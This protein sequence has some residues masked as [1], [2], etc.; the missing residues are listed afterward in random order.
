MTERATIA[1]P[2]AR[3]VFGLARDEGR[4]EAWSSMLVLICEIAAV[5][6][7]RIV[8][9]DPE[10]DRDVVAG[11]FFDLAG[12]RLDPQGRNLLRILMENRRMGL[13]PQILESYEVYRAGEER[14]GLAKVTSARPL[15][16]DQE[17]A[18][19]E[20]LG[21]SLGHGVELECVVDETLIGGAVI[22]IGDR[23]IDGSALGGL[24]QLAHDLG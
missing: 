14:S 19:R 1:R 8:I 24:E 23:V 17:K 21:R 16:G 13:L 10:T 7:M 2:Y 12:D 3:A 6:D 9:D 18:L 11:L 15:S 20:A 4:L 5:P 22:R